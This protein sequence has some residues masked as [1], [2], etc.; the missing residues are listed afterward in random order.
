MS[1]AHTHLLV[2]ALLRGCIVALLA[3]SIAS[4]ASIGIPV[5]CGETEP[6][7]YHKN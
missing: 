6:V 2:A 4:G 1:A 3:G 7:K 5:T